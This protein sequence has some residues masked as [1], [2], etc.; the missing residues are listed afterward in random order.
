MAFEQDEELMRFLIGFCSAWVV[1]D[2]CLCWTKWVG[3]V[4]TPSIT[5]RYRCGCCHESGEFNK[6]A[7]GSIRGQIGK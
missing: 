2:H 1:R 3:K 5:S 4:F 6:I 7:K